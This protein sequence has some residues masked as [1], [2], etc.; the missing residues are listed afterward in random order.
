MKK[1]IFLMVALL[2][3]GSQ[4]YAQETVEEKK[5]I[6]TK[7][8][9]ALHGRIQYDYEFLRRDYGVDSIENYKFGG[10]E[11]RRVFLSGS[12]KIYKNIKY[13]AQLEFV[14]ANI[15]Y[16]DLYIKFTDLPGIG[17]NFTVGSLAEATSL[18]MV[19][20]SKYIPMLERAM[21]TN[22]QNF[23]WNSGIMYDNM[24]LFD[25]KLGLQVSYTH[26]GKH[27][28]G[29]KDKD[30]GKGGHI[31]ARLTSPVYVN[32][33]KH[34]LVHL[35]VNFESRKRSEKPEKYTLKFRPDNHMGSKEA[36]EI[37]GVLDNQQDLG[38]ELAVN[39]GPFSFQ[40]EYEIAGYNAVIQD[41]GKD[42]DEKYNVNGFYALA[43][44]F[45]TG[46]HRG[47]KKGAY[48][49]VKSYN[50]FCLKDGDFGEFELVARYSTVDYTSIVDGDYNNKLASFG[51]GFNWYLNDHARIM[52][53]HNIKTD[54]TKDDDPTKALHADLIRLAVDF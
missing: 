1:L 54:N 51:F 31:V 10:S 33:D 45:V 7:P 53:N 21:L 2:A 39:M 11:F 20:S 24:G 23:R 5:P 30:L 25:G 26:N 4:T 52:Y 16:R 44:Y 49:R 22:T 27:N 15:G 29:F 43:S 40:T 50:N 9:V 37:P 18:S 8:S 3:F 41:G 47:F 48:S 12:G 35:G 46:G 34:Q 17:G 13:K 19:T 6:K 14:G 32:K 36:I 38:F 42:K 28:E